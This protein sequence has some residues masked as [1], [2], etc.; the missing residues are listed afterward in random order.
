MIE[1]I[2][3]LPEY[4]GL[5]DY[6]GFLTVKPRYYHIR[7]I[8]THFSTHPDYNLIDF[9]LRDGSRGTA[10]IPKAQKT[11]VA[12]ECYIVGIHGTPEYAIVGKHGTP[13]YAGVRVT[14]IR[15]FVYA[16]VA[17]TTAHFWYYGSD[18]LC[19]DSSPLKYN[20]ALKEA[21]TC[22]PTT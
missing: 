10:H 5:R 20:D 2:D 22:R 1:Y 4:D 16:L 17:N 15:W 21:E 13:E 12:G 8:R 14:M 6:G 19:R 7:V 9:E 18:T 11:L 3:P